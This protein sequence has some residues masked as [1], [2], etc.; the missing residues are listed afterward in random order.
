MI[1]RFSCPILLYHSVSADVPKAI[2]DGLHN[3]TPEVFRQQISW[4]KQRH[5][6][7]PLD[8][9]VAEGA[10]IAGKAAITFDDGY[11]NVFTEAAPILE[12]LNVPATVFLCS[13]SFRREIFWRDRI[14]YVMNNDLLGQFLTENADFCE[15]HSISAEN[16]YRASKD[17]RRI[18]SRDVDVRLQKFLEARAAE[19]D[20]ILFQLAASREELPDHPLFQ[21]GNHTSNHYA[22]SSLTSEQIHEE[23]EGNHRFLREDLGLEL[24]TVLSVPFGN[25]QDFDERAIRVGEDLGYRGVVLSRSVLNAAWNPRPSRLRSMN[26]L[27]RF[28]PQSGFASFPKLM[29]KCFVKGILQSGRVTPT[30]TGIAV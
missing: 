2:A 1:S 7:V 5:E 22:L 16:F 17:P 10:S 15:Q 21:Y 20:P 11:R 3:V 9:L 14:R 6:I 28:M 13:V 12:Q 29:R 18:N 25:L 4:I 30:D 19:P 23:I 24:S 27:E 26:C 8:E